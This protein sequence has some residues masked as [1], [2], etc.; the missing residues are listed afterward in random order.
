MRDVEAFEKLTPTDKS[1]KVYGKDLQTFY[2]VHLSDAQKATF[3]GLLNAGKV[4]FEYPG[5]FCTTPY[6]MEK[7]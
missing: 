6:F 5:F 1:Y 4:F 7:A 2:F 3:V